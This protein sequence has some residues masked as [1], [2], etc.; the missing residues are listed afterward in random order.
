LPPRSKERR[1]VGS[2]VVHHV[3]A[4]LPRGQGPLCRGTF[5]PFRREAPIVPNRLRLPSSAPG[6]TP[7]PI[8]LST[9][10]TPRLAGRTRPSGY[11]PLH[12]RCW[13]KAGMSHPRR[14]PRSWPGGTRPRPGTADATPSPRARARSSHLSSARVHPRMLSSK[15]QWKHACCCYSAP[16]PR[17]LAA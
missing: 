3:R 8:T 7:Y 13:V 2:P 4:V 10:S 9:S 11:P 14:S 17:M 6:L 12:E 5:G 16:V 15:T 1:L